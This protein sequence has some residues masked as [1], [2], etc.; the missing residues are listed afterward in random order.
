MAYTTILDELRRS[1]VSLDDAFER[2]SEWAMDT[3]EE[4]GDPSLDAV[5]RQNNAAL[6]S[7]GLPL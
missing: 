7:V 2:L 3:A 5:A 1:G 4:Q 6:A